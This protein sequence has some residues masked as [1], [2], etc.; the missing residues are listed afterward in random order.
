MWVNISFVVKLCQAVKGQPANSG[1][2]CYNRMVINPGT[3]N[4]WNSN[5]GVRRRRDLSLAANF[6]VFV[7]ISGS[8]ILWAFEKHKQRVERGYAEGSAEPFFPKTGQAVIYRLDQTSELRLF[9]W[10]R[11]D[12][13]KLEEMEEMIEMIGR[14]LARQAA[15]R[16]NQ[17]LPVV[18]RIHMV[19]ETWGVCSN[20]PG[21]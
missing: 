12:F 13:G 9:G 20:V 17:L 10:D 18:P 8:F 16:R 2:E 1:L 3:V 6:S 7:G 11:T 14:E 19:Q 5:E 4:W 21:T 15:K